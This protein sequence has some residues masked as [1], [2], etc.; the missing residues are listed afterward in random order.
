MNAM[1]ARRLSTPLLVLLPLLLPVLL[2]ACR[3]SD[4][5]APRRL[6]VYAAGPRGLAEALA[7]SF[8][9]ETG[10]PVDLFSATTGQLMARLEAERHNR[11]ADVI[12]LASAL[13]AEHLARE[14]RLM[15]LQL[16]SDAPASPWDDPK[17]MYRALGAAAVGIAL[18]DDG[19]ARDLRR[20]LEARSDSA[21]HGAGIPGAGRLDLDGREE[22]DGQDELDAA[23]DLDW[24]AALCGDFAAEGGSI[25]MPSPIRSGTSADFVLAYLL[26]RG[27]A[28]WEC[29][30]EARRMGLEFAAANSQALAGLSAGTYRAIIGA[31]DY[32]V[33][34]EID[35]GAPIRLHFPRSGAPVVPRPAA[36]L[37]GTRRAEEAR[38]FIAHC[39]SPAGQRLI[40]EARMI[41]ADATLRAALDRP[42]P[43][44]ELPLDLDLALERQVRIL[45]RFQY[46]IERPQ[47]SRPAQ[48]AP[49]EAARR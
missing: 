36:I 40:A 39:L 20:G 24:T 12:L 27:E 38:R 2:P 23:S 14:G 33:L 10:I 13:A 25:V 47:T 41:P 32:L 1:R 43:A 22:L 19:S 30:A 34:R 29:F 7:N 9:A 6:V 26:E 31:V 48:R 49:E 35:R 44:R 46:Q 21:R 5:Q 42:M 11:R 15:A 45:R 37:T 18:R 28:G 3:E 17:G 16:E 4:R 8:T